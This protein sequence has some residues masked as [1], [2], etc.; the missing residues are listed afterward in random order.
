MFVPLY[1]HNPLEHIPRPFV[2]W[3]IIAV[4]CLVYFVFQSDMV[5]EAYYAAAFGL[6]LTPLYLFDGLPAPEGLD[7]VPEWTTV[8]TYALV[9]GDVWHLLGN[10]VFLW[11]FGDNVEDAVG[12][13]RYLAFYVLTAA[14]GGLTHAAMMPHSDTLLVGASGAVA[15]VVG[16][17]LMLHPRTKLWILVLGRIPLR[18]TAR[19]PL[20]L[21]V[22]IQVVSAV[23]TEEEAVAWWA[24]VGGLVA[25][26]LLILVMRRPGVPLFDRNLVAQAPT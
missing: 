9:H 17:Y 6:G 10:M 19:W 3:S 16:A 11:V 20:A 21:W 13:R 4:T 22:A 18:L 24:H 12:H 26:V 14:A 23:T 8:A 2:N 5:V 15:G 7:L 1:D 25:G